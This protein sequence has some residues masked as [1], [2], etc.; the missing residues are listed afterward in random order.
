MALP[1]V[2]HP[3][4]AKHLLFLSPQLLLLSCCSLNM[5]GTF[6]LPLTLHLSPLPGVLFPTEKH[7]ILSNLLEVCTQ[8][9]TSN[10]NSPLP[11]LC[12]T[13]LLITSCHLTYYIFGLFAL[14]IVLLLPTT[15]PMTLGFCLCHSL[16]SP[17][18]LE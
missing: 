15:S 7:D 8:M 9:P 3:Y 17:Q 1:D 5:P 10:A 14:F 13:F 4:P 12:F 16:L 6:Q 11:L 2:F 18:H